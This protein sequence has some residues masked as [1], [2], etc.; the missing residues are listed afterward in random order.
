MINL[1]CGDCLSLLKDVPENSIDS[2]IA[3]LPY[4]ITQAKWDCE[5]NLDQLWIEYKR[6]AKPNASFVLF[7]SQPFTSKLIS[8][9]IKEFKYCW[10]W[11]KEQGTGFLNSKKQPLRCIEEICIFY[12]EQCTYNPQMVQLAEIRKNKLP[13]KS[14][15]LI[16][17]VKS[18]NQKNDY[19]VYTHSFPKN[20]LK[21]SREKGNKKFHSTQKP[22]E[23]MKYLVKTYTNE[24]DMVLDNV[25]GSGTTGVACKEL[26]RNFIGIELDQE[27]FNLAQK[28]I[29]FVDKL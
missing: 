29:D 24:G 6:V 4:G 11:E 22:L 1:L 16:G 27:M 28:R 3:D 12:K 17:H 19:V 18:F 26:N 23:L 14:S 20:I 2:I 9:N 8:S 5:I 13:T 15:E 7:A 25:M 21:F 10:Y